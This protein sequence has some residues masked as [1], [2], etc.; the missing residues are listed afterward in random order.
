MSTGFMQCLTVPQTSETE[1]EK[2]WLLSYNMSSVSTISRLYFGAGFGKMHEVSLPNV[3]QKQHQSI[4]PKLTGD[5]LSIKYKKLYAAY[6]I[7][8]AIGS[9]KLQHYS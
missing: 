7:V 9:S 5:H 4:W 2:D 6:E 1:Q 8:Q 3:C